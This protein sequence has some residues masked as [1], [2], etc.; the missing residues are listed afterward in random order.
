MFVIRV[1]GNYLSEATL[2]SLE[3][4]YLHLQVKVLVV[5]G[6]EGCGA[7]KASRQKMSKIEREPN[8]LSL[9]LK[10]VKAGLEERRLLQVYDERAQDREAVVTNVQNQV[11]KLKKIPKVAELI[12]SGLLIVVGA[13]YDMSSGIVDFL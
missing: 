4:A 3:Y 7:V 11:K 8:S 1:A 5:L 13:F 9:L 12:K 10:K 2:G 6:H